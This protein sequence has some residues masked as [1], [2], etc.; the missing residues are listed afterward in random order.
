MRKGM[1]VVL[2]VCMLL[3]VLVNNLPQTIYAKEKFLGEADISAITD[4]IDLHNVSVTKMNYPNQGDNEC[5]VRQVTNQ[6]EINTYLQ[7]ANWEVCYED[8][9]M[10]YVYTRETYTQEQYDNV[11]VFLV[12]D[13]EKAVFDQQ[14]TVW[15]Y[16][17]GKIHIYKRTLLKEIFDSNYSSSYFT[18]G[19]I[20]NTDGS[21]SYMNGDKLAV[22]GEGRA[23]N[24]NIAF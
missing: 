8:V 10:P 11:M 6:I 21:L 17:S 3:L 5:Q 18:P 22:R 4:L 13:D 15:R 7:N 12:N 2:V 20:V 9:E 23:Y 16:A 14:I 19:N 1:R 24:Y